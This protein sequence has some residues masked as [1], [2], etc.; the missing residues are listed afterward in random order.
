MVN[1]NKIVA[2]L[3]IAG[4]FFLST[5]MSLYPQYAIIVLFL[6][7]GFI[8]F[9]TF[10]LKKNWLLYAIILTLFLESKIFSFYL[11][12]ARIR[13]L[14]ILEV[15]AVCYF[16]LAVSLGRIRLKKTPLDFPLWCY[17]LI[18]FIALANTVWIARSAKIAILLFSLIILYYVI[19]NFLSTQEIFDKA[20]NLLLYTGIIEIIYGLY[21]VL[22]GMSNYIFGFNLPVGHLGIIHKDYIGSPWGRPYG[23][24]VEPDWYGA[25][26]MF[27]AIVFIS[28]YYSKIKEKKRFYYYG[29]V[30]SLLGLFFSFVRAAWIG[31]VVGAMTLLFCRY[32]TKLSRLNL[33]LYITRISFF[34]AVLVIAIL[35]SSTLRTILRERFYSAYTGSR[36]GLE[37]IRVQQMKT[38]FKAFLKHPILGNGPGSSAFNYLAEEY[39]EEYAKN[40]IK[41]EMS[42]GISAG[43]NPSIITTVLED[44]GIIGL[45][46]F[47]ILVYKITHYNYKKIQLINNQYAIVATGLFGG[48]TGLFT[49]YIFTQGFWI[50]FTWVFLAFDIISL[51]LGARNKVAI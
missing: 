2:I 23:T 12:G 10:L 36:I 26:S 5:F 30:I 15:I 24:F 3:T 8:V 28:L 31:F 49:S 7:G 40:I 50:P 35:M 43:F 19:I 11:F 32:R 29:M 1:I 13:I 33:S 38:S 17:I 25:V 41:V 48:L 16:F 27:F 47:I 44:T 37:N 22:A 6:L 42:L 18:N 45:I 20:F 4:I 9:L 39:G 51:K 14:Q 46:I 34:V 21:Q